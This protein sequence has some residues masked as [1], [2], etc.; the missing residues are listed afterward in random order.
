MAISRAR[1]LGL[2]LL[3][4]SFFFLSFF[5]FLWFFLFG[6]KKEK[7]I[8]AKMLFVRVSVVEMYGG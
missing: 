2:H 5:Q 1:A 3:I 6:R 8:H 7:N 4:S